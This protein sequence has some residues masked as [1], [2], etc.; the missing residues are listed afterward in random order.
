MPFTWA[1]YWRRVGVIFVVALAL[2]L[3]VMAYFNHGRVEPI[4]VLT[5]LV[6]SIVLAVVVAFPLTQRIPRS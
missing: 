5:A 3:V 6:D 2:S 4:V 1:R